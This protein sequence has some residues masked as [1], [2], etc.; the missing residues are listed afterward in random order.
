MT[1]GRSTLGISRHS[2][3]YI[4]ED[5]WFKQFE[6]K[7]EKGAVQPRNPQTLFD[8]INSIMNGT[9]AR[10]NSVEDAVEDMKARS[11]LTAYLERLSTS[12]EESS[13]DN[14][15]VAQNNTETARSPENDQNQAMEKKIPIVFKKCPQ[16]S[17]TLDNYIRDTKGN[18][19]VPAIIDKLKSIHRGDVSDAKDW[20]DDNLILEV[21]KR[22][23]EAKK[24][25]PESYQNY[26][27]LG[28]RD[29]S[30]ESEVDPSNR[31]AF[32]ALNPAKL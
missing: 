23:L 16:A 24:T 12:S 28:T 6:K 14:R 17:D 9:K 15:K 3:E 5:H 29:T 30:G 26:A 7:L 25:N 18:L 19:P 21:S 22:N 32:F 13:D 1:R 4:S 11:G 2:D 10:Y 27:H 20:E 8:Q 31:D